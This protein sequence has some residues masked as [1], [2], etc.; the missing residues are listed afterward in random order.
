MKR[1]VYV[2][3]V[4]LGLFILSACSNGSDKEAD[5]SKEKSDPKAGGTMVYAR[6]ADSVGLDPINITDG[7]SI[8]VT[9]AIFETLFEYD[10]DLQLQP[11]LAESYETSE[12]GLTWT[13]ALK[14]DVK[15]HDGTD[16]NADAVV[17]NFERWMDPDN[18]YHIGDFP[19]YPFLYGGFKG[20]EDHKIDYVKAV[21]EHT[22]EIKLK[23]KI[24]PFISYLAIPMFGMASP[25]A[26]EQYNE[27]FFENPVG[28]GPFK[29]DSWTRN[30]KII[31][32]ANEDYYV[33]NQPLLDQIIFTVVPDNSAR[34]NVLLSGEADFID[35]MNPEDAKTVE[36]DEN[37][38]LVKRPSF[39]EGFMVMNTQKAPFDDVKVRQ[40]INMAIDKKALVNGFY[41]G[42]AEVAKNPVPP[43]LW[44]YHDE[45]EDYKFDVDTAKAL[46]AEAGYPDGFETEIWTMNNPRPYLPQP[47]KTAEAIQANLQEIGIEAK[48]VTYEWATY[49]EKTG[50]G[51]HPMALYGWTGVMADP[52][53]FLYPNLSNTNM[54]VPAN[55]KAFYD[56][57][58]FQNLIE[59]ARVTFDQD[60][61][62]KLYK[63]AQE[64]FHEDAPWV[65]LAHTTPPIGFAKYVKGYEPHPMENDNFAVMYLDK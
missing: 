15:F 31:V 11:K 19:Y 1:F 63:K 33:E 37:L 18:E 57:E 58:E 23:E 52:D 43:A 17:F 30:D 48:I 22:V 32:K 34:L 60:E 14:K 16:F 55:N 45:I 50:A 24:A 62:I 61:R 12:D 20:D 65:P 27:R 28:T 49:L 40:A 38:E 2:I 51:Q 4:F 6:G 5:A 54:E 46:L 9:H 44:G 3:S 35:G 26:I 42:F 41:S 39:N 56:N 13:L 21:D 25:T 47:M 59:Q 7:E 53:N 8:R 10:K 64:I 36:D 29:F